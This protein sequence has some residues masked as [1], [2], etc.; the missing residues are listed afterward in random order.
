[1]DD[2]NAMLDSLAVYEM[3]NL[4]HDIEISSTQQPDCSLSISLWYASVYKLNGVIL[5]VLPIWIEATS[6]MNR[7]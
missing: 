7:I 1:M 3:R 6:E 4:S 2:F 5:S